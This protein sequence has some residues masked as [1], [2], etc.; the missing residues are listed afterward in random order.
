MK[1]TKAH[2]PTSQGYTTWNLECGRN[3]AAI[4]PLKLNNQY[5]K[6]RSAPMNRGD[7]MAA[8]IEIGEGQSAGGA[9][10]S[11]EKSDQQLHTVLENLGRVAPQDDLHSGFTPR[12]DLEALERKSI[13]DRL[14]AIENQTKKRSSRGF[15]RYLL[16]ICIGV[17]ATLAWQSYGEAAKQMFAAK[18][19]ELGWSPETK[20]MIANWVEQLG[21]T[22]P[23]QAAPVAQTAPAAVAPSVPVAPSID[24]A[25]VHQIAMDLTA[26]R[27]TVAQ[28][29]AG[30]D[31]MA[32]EV[33]RLQAADQEILVKIPE[34]PPP[35]PIAAA[36]AVAARPAP[37]GAPSE[38]TQNTAPT[39][40]SIALRASCGPDVQK[41]C[42]GIS[43]ENGDAIKCLS[44]HR[45]ELSRTCDLYF[46]EMPMHR[47][48]QT[49]P[50][51]VTPPSSR[52]PVPSYIPQ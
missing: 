37:G 52:A 40:A 35:P 20:Q 2:R 34:P 50:K 4:N 8:N 48:A 33:D 14:G 15:T 28:I 19:P 25:E 6:L 24:P 42:R 3:D 16:A 22:K 29:T 27:Q 17:A 38:N 5:L 23:P 10:G 9:A 46:N 11:D 44:S 32:R 49:K 30:Q 18:A 41:L 26:L 12:L 13:Y 7:E 47:A 21:W 39:S 43:I 1:K 36:P 51:P 31:Q 45:M